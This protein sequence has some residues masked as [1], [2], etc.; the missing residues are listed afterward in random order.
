MSKLLFNTNMNFDFEKEHEY[1]QITAVL[2]APHALEMI[3]SSGK[4]MV[5]KLP[6]C[7]QLIE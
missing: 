1:L 4:V 2:D 5:V 7:T 3:I 6:L